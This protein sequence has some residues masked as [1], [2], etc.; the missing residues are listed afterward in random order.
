[1]KNSTAQLE[2]Y[3]NALSDL[4]HSL[5]TPLAVLR[6]EI[7][8][9]PDGSDARR[10][11]EEQ[12][13]RMDLTVQYQLQRAAASGR[14]ALTPSVGILPVAERIRNSLLKV[15]SDKS[16]DFE[17]DLS[18]TLLFKG[19]EGDLTE[20]LGNLLD[21]A[22]KW[23]AR[24][25]RLRGSEQGED[26]TLV[27]EDDGPGVSQ[28]ALAHLRERGARGDPTRPG[29]GI[30]LAVVDELVSGVY[31]GSIEVD[32][33]DLGGARIQIRIRHGS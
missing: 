24:R 14:T 15:Y 28:A 16:L 1:M 29:Q 22:C 9:L 31:G 7:E 20:L 10:S 23:A 6:N 26:L 17:I 4:A 18:P 11:L 19:D 30:G 3:R 21:N 2:R 13:Q 27:I 8:E 5:K 33:S 32:R 12:V 25:V